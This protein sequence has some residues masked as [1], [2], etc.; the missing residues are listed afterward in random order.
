M[1]VQGQYCTETRRKRY[2]M[3]DKLKILKCLIENRAF[4]P[5]HA[6][7]AKELGYKGR[8]TVYR[9]MDGSVKDGTASKMWDLI[10]LNYGLDD[11]GIY[12]L[13]RM[14]FCF[15]HF[16]GT[17][18]GE[19]NTSHKEWAK[20]LMIFLIADVYDY[21][22][23]GFK[24][25]TASVLIDLK[26]DEPDVYWGM[27]TL[28]Y[29]HAQKID[30]YGEGVE[31]AS[32]RI[33]TQLDN[34]LHDLY[35]EKAD[36]HD[37]AANLLSLPPAKNLC[38]LLNRC[39]VLF[40]NYAE[41]N[42]RNEATKELCLFGFGKRSYWC[43]PGCCYGKGHDVW[44]LTEQSYGRMTNGF[45]FALHLRA[46]CDIQTFSLED[47]FY[48]EFWAAKGED[49]LPILQ[50]CRRKGVERQWCHYL[51]DYDQET[52]EL[53]FEP[54]A[55]TDNTFELPGTLRM[56]SLENS[57]G[58]YEN[59]WAN[60]MAKWDALQ[61]SAMFQKAKETFSGITDMAGTYNIVDVSISKTALTL[62]V[63]HDCHTHEYR[64][65][66]AE[67]DFLAEINPSQ[68]V[69]IAR[70][71]SDGLLYACWPELGYSIKLSEFVV[72]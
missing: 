12:N 70:Y 27:V 22:S 65:S 56:I 29:I 4:A 14:F 16:Y 61:G 6:A 17:L 25:E 1:G 51:Y 49:D 35:P 42:Y 48:L 18:V 63:E 2:T 53:H 30:V 45:Y 11:M 38:G 66:I 31:T 7:L 72:Q 57:E 20:N 40:R 58:L 15:R 71:E 5:S 32:R 36:A 10:K 44:L 39:I 55:D 8:M 23:P 62:S 69:I 60:I 54:L 3:D 19:M 9:L 59:E 52:H 37:V 67:Y 50:V 41:S 43:K 24:T 28:V 33:I 47:V 64:L 46:G 68:K 21:C 34:L 13:A 26:A